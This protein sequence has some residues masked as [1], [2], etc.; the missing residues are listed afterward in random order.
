MKKLFF[1]CIIAIVAV[2]TGCKDLNSV[3]DDANVYIVDDA[4]LNS[5]E[6]TFYLRD[7]DSPIV[8]P[9]VNCL[10]GVDYPAGTIITV[11]D[12]FIVEKVYVTNALSNILL[13][14]MTAILTACVMYFFYETK[15]K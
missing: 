5:D 2:F 11:N 9:V 1:M 6:M 4:V 10:G 7:V 8:V 14:C 15:K 3:P 13:I 12:D